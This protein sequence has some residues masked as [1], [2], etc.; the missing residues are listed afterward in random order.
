MMIDNVLVEEV[1]GNDLE[2]ITNFQPSQI[3]VSQMLPPGKVLN[4]GAATQTNVTLTAAINGT[5]VG[6][7]LPL[8]SLAPGATAE[9]LLSTPV[10]FPAGNIAMVYSITQDQPDANPEN[11]VC[12]FNFKGTPNVLAIDEV[13]DITFAPPIISSEMTA[14]GNVFHINQSVT[15][16]QVILGFG[17]DN[18]LNL[19]LSLYAMTGELTTAS[20][21]IFTTPVVR[22]GPGFFSFNVPATT[23]NPGTYYL[24][25]NILGAGYEYQ[26][27]LA[28][29]KNHAKIS[30]GRTNAGALIRAWEFGGT[31]IRMVMT[32][33]DCAKPT[34]LSVV[35]NF[36][37]A[38]FS[39]EGNAALYK[40]VVNNGSGDYIYYTANNSITVWNLPEGLPHTWNITAIC[41]ATHSSPTITGQPF[42][43]L[44]CGSA[45]FPIPF[46]E[47]FE[48]TVFPQSCWRIY[49]VSGNP[50]DWNLT[51]NFKHTGKYAIVH[52]ANIYDAQEGWIVMP[53]MSIPSTG[54]YFL[55]FWSIFDWSQYHSYAGVWV[56]TTGGDPTTS[57]F[58]EIKEIIGSEVSA[59][60][61]QLEVALA[62]F[63]GKEIYIGFKYASNE[64]N[65]GDDWY[66]D[67]IE[68]ISPNQY[69]VTLLA[70]PEDGGT[71]TGSG[72]YLPD[73]SVTVMAI[74][75]ANH[76][77]LNW[78]KESEIVSTTPIYSFIV[79]D[80]VTLT[81]NFKPLS[82]S[83]SKLPAFTIHPNPATDRLNIVRT[84]TDK[85]QVKIFNM[86]GAMIQSFENNEVEFEIN[87]EKFSSGIYL[88]LL[89]GNKT[90]SVQ[91]FFK[92]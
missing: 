41:D 17:A 24:C 44:T 37:W 14:I 83:E 76:S 67:D 58:T 81:A 89:V 46:F 65:D 32:V 64:G 48:G 7:S 23:L 1:A 79:T 21:P 59:N 63:S 52:Q 35:P 3:P 74:T 30:Y 55:K 11:N 8:A 15:L 31:A 27:Y 77:F 34:N 60:W 42:S 13:I 84:T 75:N 69:L 22:T 50:P 16:S 5:P 36:T 2:N 51:T 12:T 26:P 91:K 71:L 57:E 92:E 9:L 38:S 43:T 62:E 28:F 68:I 10:Y 73:A 49:N 61:K 72:Y 78:T 88:I 6:N 53:Q 29:D 87:V 47:G 19:S 56:S 40:L 86:Q 39:W 4:I 20:T 33:N 54:N 82:I 85:V 18:L 80:E 25:V 70:N 45:G 66:I 90:N